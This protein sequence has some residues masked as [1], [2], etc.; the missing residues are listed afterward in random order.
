MWLL[1]SP[2]IGS[3]REECWALERTRCS[4]VHLGDKE[5]AMLCPCRRGGLNVEGHT[6]FK[7]VP[8]SRAE[9]HILVLLL[10]LPAYRSVCVSGCQSTFVEVLLLIYKVQITVP[11]FIL[12]QQISSCC[13]R[14]CPGDS[15]VWLST[16]SPACLF[17]LQHSSASCL[18]L[19]LYS[20]H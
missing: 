12:M 4:W 7:G 15:S 8:Q 13:A 20:R 14:Y 2:V 6:Y 19:S 1:V 18:S 11:C 3:T 5:A 16:V 10:L 9:L 17:S